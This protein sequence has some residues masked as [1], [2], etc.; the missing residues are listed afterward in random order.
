MATDGDIDFSTYTRE[1]LDSAVTRMDHERYPINSRKLIDEYQR[2]KVEEKK[3]A[4]LAL[5]TKTVVVPDHML[6]VARALEVKF[7]PRASVFNW[8]GPSRNDFH[9]IGSG[10]VRV[11]DA[12]I[13]VKGRRFVYWLGMPVVNTDELGR[14]YVVNVEALG[15]AVRFELRV[16][17]EKVRGLTVWL[18]TNQE[19]EELSKLLPSERTPDFTPQLQQHVEFEQSLIAQSPKTPITYTLLGLCVFVYV[20]TAL[21]TDQWSGLDGPSLVRLGSNFGPYTTD[22]DWWRL[23][24]SMFLHGGLL[25]LAFNMWA[26]VSFGR[27]VERL[28]GSSSYALVYLIAGVAGSLGSVIW[29]PA[30]NSVGASG[31]IF[32]LLG[33]L[34]AAQVRSDGSIPINILRPLRNSSLVFTGFALLAGLR[35]G[36]VDNAA[37][38]RGLAAGFLL[39][40]A[41]SRPLTGRRLGVGGLLRRLGAAALMGIMILGVGVSA[42]EYESKLLTGESLY[43]ANTHWFRQRERSTLD[44]FRELAVLAQ[45]GKLNE[46]AYADRIEREVIPFWSEAE[47][48]FANVDL[49]T[50][51]G[52][53]E[54]LQ[55]LQSVS[56]DRLH[57]YQLTVQSLRNDDNKMADQAVEE[58]QRIEHRAS[59]RA[60]VWAAKQ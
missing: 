33:A 25:H 44:R 2:R 60:Q 5:E 28:F 48:R 40:L 8:L 10:T 47:E 7:E 30:V 9:L 6:S 56:H 15:R 17:G 38:C 4:A 14:R 45:K 46:K 57:A 32:G 13:C 21:G 11:D 16:P 36:A 22:G 3:A 55:W 20:G 31:A 58:L 37:H 12:L 54:S 24:T 18:K 41:L 39:G 29:N 34:I 35:S 51:S 43:W 27:L 50:S 42:A 19:A 26:L 59:E 23:V 53:Y 49:P 1:Q 52:N